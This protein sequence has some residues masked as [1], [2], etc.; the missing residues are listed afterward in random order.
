MAKI[1]SETAAKLVPGFLNDPSTE[2]RRDAVAQLISKGNGLVNDDKAAAIVTY[3]GALDA[4]RD[5]DQI[6]EIAKALTE[7]LGQSV[8]LPRHFGFLTDWQVVG[9]F[10]NNERKGFLEEFPPE[11][12]VDL[13]AAHPGKEEEAKWQLLSSEDAY[14]KVD[15]NKPFGKLKE[16]TGYAFTEFNASEARPAELRLGSK[17]AWK[18]WLNGK[19]LFGRDEYHR[20]QRI[21]QY[22]MPIQLEKGKNTILVKLCQNEQKE[23][24]TVEWEFQ[25]RVCDATGTAI[26]ST[27]RAAK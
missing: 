18:V 2:L 1:D 15:L 8:D 3:R 21:D 23:K 9:P 22:K 5:V 4:A 11:K 12:K 20:G 10:H 7:T 17:N 26:L 19:L 27:D 13:K 16:V 14:G 24:W 25:L 6:Q